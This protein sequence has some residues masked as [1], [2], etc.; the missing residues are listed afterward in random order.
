[1][2]S[3][4]GSV[5]FSVSTIQ[6]QE[7]KALEQLSSGSRINHASDDAVSLAIAS[8]ISGANSALSQAAITAS[9]GQA[10][11][12]TAN[13]GLSSVSGVLGQLQSLA[14][15]AQ[16]GILT[17]AA[18]ADLNTQFQNLLGEVD[19]TANSSQFAGQNLLDGSYNS[20]FLLGSSSGDTVN[21]TLGSATTS[22][23]GL[24]GLDISTPANA[25]TAL[26]AITNAINNV[27]GQQANIAAASENFSTNANTIATQQ[28]ANNASLA[29]LTGA[30]IGQALIQ[31]STSDALSQSNIAALAK[32]QQSQRHLIDL[33]Q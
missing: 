4:S 5:P 31:Q 15:S 32:H 12:N 13:S 8:Q 25:A 20:N 19:A 22:A 16:S 28:E 21:V 24:S 1:M 11:L 7:K 17:P 6:A 33:L 30:D 26:D 18:S 14:A 2:T 10:L 29:A 23:L 3:I 9:T 27:A